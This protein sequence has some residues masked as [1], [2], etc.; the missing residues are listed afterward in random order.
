MFIIK[1]DIYLKPFI[2]KKPA[3]RGLIVNYNYIN[4]YN[5]YSQFYGRKLI[6]IPMNS[7]HLK[8]TL[9]ILEKKS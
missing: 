8:C 2:F 1:R 4:N 7:K 9:K 6:F 5:Y 3:G